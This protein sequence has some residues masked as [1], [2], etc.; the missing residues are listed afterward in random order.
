MRQYASGV[1]INNFT[2]FRLNTYRSH[3][4]IRHARETDLRLRGQYAISEVSVW[5]MFVRRNLVL[6]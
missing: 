3:I 2:I 5:L 1:C 6:P 4:A